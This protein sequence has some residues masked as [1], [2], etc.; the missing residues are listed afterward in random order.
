MTKANP[1]KIQNKKKK[2]ASALKLNKNQIHSTQLCLS[3]TLRKTI[4]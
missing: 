4:Q 2:I 3:V 1:R